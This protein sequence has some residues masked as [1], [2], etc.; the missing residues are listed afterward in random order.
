[1][2]SSPTSRISRPLIRFDYG[3][4]HREGIKVPKLGSQKFTM[5]QQLIDNEKKLWRKIDRHIKEND[6]DLLFD[7]DDVAEAISDIHS[8]VNSFEDVHVSLQRELGDEQYTES[9]T[10]YD[11]QITTVT[12]WTTKAKMAI[13]EKKA[14]KA[15]FHQVTMQQDQN[16]LFAEEKFLRDK[17]IRDLQTYRDEN[18]FFVSDL[19]TNVS[20]VEDLQGQ[21]TDLFFRIEGMGEN[22]AKLFGERYQIH[23]GLMNDYI[24]EMRKRIQDKK[25]EEQNIECRVRT[26]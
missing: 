15:N 10:D 25:V 26:D 19:T 5:A 16:K 8:L 13:K 18:S 6:I 11:K 22:F 2:S 12:D 14:A 17:I 4:Y 3:T 1:M 23:C 7:V 9:Y 21:Y 24:R 20:A